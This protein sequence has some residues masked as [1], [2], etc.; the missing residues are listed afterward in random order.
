MRER[1]RST[2]AFC[3]RPSP[4]KTASRSTRR[5][6]GSSSPS[7]PH[8]GAGG[9]ARGDR[10]AARRTDQGPDRPP[11]RHAACQRRGIRRRGRAQ[12]SA[13]RGRRPRR[14]SSRLLG[15][16]GR[17]ISRRHFL[18]RARSAS[19]PAALVSSR[20]RGARCG[21]HLAR[22]KRQAHAPAARQLRA[23]HRRSRRSRQANRSLPPARLA[24]DEPR[25]AAC[26]GRA[27]VRRTAAHRQ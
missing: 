25:A 3:A 14:P 15:R 7:R 16:R 4:A 1:S 5:E 24:R 6:T 26:V 20:G 10:G 27:R 22:I 19:R 18:D 23:A 2:G 8:R 17:P 11:H 12:G 21:R 13:D 9:R